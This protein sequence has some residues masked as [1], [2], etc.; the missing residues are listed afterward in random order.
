MSRLREYVRNQVLED[1]EV[2]VA[3]NVLS[4]RRPPPRAAERFTENVGAAA[5]ELINR[6]AER[7]DV[8]ASERQVHA[9]AL[10]EQ[11]I[12]QLKIAHEK[13][14]SADKMKTECISKVQDADR[15]L[16]RASS[17][18]AAIEAKLSAA[19]Q[20]AKAAEVRASAAEDALGQIEEALRTRILG[21]ICPASTPASHLVA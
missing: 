11:A 10:V 2:D 20:R 1:Y 13:V 14:R 5:I 7:I 8:Y 6:A 15:L 4:F 21:K 12:E 9:E 3:E 19:E 16:E 18:I 17:R